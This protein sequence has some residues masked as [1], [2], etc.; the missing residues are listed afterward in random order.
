MGDRH[1]NEQQKPTDAMP[2]DKRLKTYRVTLQLLEYQTAYIE[3]TSPEDA[4]EKAQGMYDETYVEDF[5]L[6]EC[7]LQEIFVT[8][9]RS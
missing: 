6:D 1:V 9:C 8:E 3:A 4:R 5:G 7:D 2:V